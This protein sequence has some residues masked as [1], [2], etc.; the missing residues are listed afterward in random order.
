MNTKIVD[1]LTLLVQANIKLRY[2]KEVKISEVYNTFTRTCKPVIILSVTNINLIKKNLIYNALAPLNETI[3]IDY[4][5]EYNGE[6]KLPLNMKVKLTTQ[7]WEEYKSQK[8]PCVGCSYIN[9]EICSS[10]CQ[11]LFNTISKMKFDNEELD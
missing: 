8:D 2:I 4:L 10:G 1:V 6:L 3:N 5:G 7:E 11:I 9:Q